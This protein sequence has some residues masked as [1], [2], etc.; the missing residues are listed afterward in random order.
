V[1]KV[2]IE[3]HKEG[4]TALILLNRPH[5]K[6]A[7]DIPALE[8]LRDALIELDSDPDLRTGIITGAGEE[9]FCS[10][11]DIRGM[12]IDSTLAAEKQME[13]TG[14]FPATL[15]RGLEITKPLIA[16]VNGAALGGGLEIVLCCDLRIA[17]PEAVFGSPE[18]TLGL[19]PGWGGTQRLPRQVPW[20]MAAQLLL[21]GNTIDAA[22]ALR[23]G[24]INRVVPRPVLLQTALEW[25]EAI[26][27][28]A[29]L[30]V[31]AAKEAML[32]GAQL[33]LNEGLELEDALVTCL[34]TSR[35]FK[36]GIEAF[37]E[38]RKPSFEG[39]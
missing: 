22:E 26:C 3:Y 24:L 36:E 2:V 14:A 13:L 6:N 18:V 30:A 28:A 31:R 4:K 19:I 8:E 7:L 39:R 15:M 10:G 25:A 38:K 11:W 20:C 1:A 9:A 29:P 17:S 33:P 23:I 21:T 37:R 27:Q 16:A 5:L 34:K 12:D 32:K 35:D